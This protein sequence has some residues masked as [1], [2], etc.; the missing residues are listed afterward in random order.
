MTNSSGDYTYSVTGQLQ[1]SFTTN[2]EGSVAYTHQKSMDVTSTT[3]ST[4]G[5]NY[6]YQRDVSGD[7]LDKSVS[8]S[9]YDQPHRIV[10]T[11]HVSLQDAHRPVGDLHRQL[12]RAVRLCV[13]RRQR[14]RAP[15]TRTPT[16]SRR[17][18]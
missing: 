3:S 4:A 18:I 9:K 5:S 7:I 1:K 10:A 17:T 2:F 15:A 14:A 11:G 16:V 12:G 13:R 6:R 8:K